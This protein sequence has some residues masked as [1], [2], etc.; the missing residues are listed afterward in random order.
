VFGALGAAG[1]NVRAI[2]Q[3]A[4]ERNISVVVPAKAAT[5]ALRAVHAGF[6]LSDHTLS[7]G[8]IGPGTVG[9][10][11]LSQIASQ[12]E[13]LRR[14]FKLD[15]RVRGLLSS[16]KMR[17]SDRGMAPGAW[18]QACAD[19]D[20]APDLGRFVEHIAADHLPHHVII[21]CTASGEI[22]RHYAAWLA[23]GIHVVTPNKKANSAPWAD[24]QAVLAARRAGGTH[25]LY[26]ATVG[27]GLPVIQTLRDLRETGDEI[28]GI[29]GIFS[30]TLAYLFNLYDGTRAFSDIVGEAKQLGYTEPDPRDDLSGMDVAR[31]LIIL[32]REMGLALEMSDVTVE[33]LVPAGLEQGSIEEFLARLPAHDAVMRERFERAR[34]A[35]KVLRYVG[36]L[37]A[38]GKATVGI[39]ECDRGHPFAH[40]A[41]TD[42]VVRFA[43]SRYSTNPLIVQGPGAGPEVTA[44]GIF[45]DLLRLSAYLGA[46]I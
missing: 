2:A 13:R 26:E 7:V 42:N 6:Y 20:P 24:Y 32:G 29:E 12:S 8:I 30:G 41:L 3:G 45:A 44:G 14:D 28:T 15:L 21:D 23:A 10:V 36:R 43:T 33:S 22:A 27:A 5:R 9:R 19:S 11:L 31:K 16:K 17:L 37:S 18:E 46:R 34:A 1:V 39:V 4:S 35:G 38:D 25:Y 40:I